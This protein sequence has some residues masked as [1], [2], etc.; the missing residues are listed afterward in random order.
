EVASLAD[1]NRAFLFI[2]PTT[3]KRS[4]VIDREDGSR[5]YVPVVDGAATAT[6]AGYDD[7]TNVVELPAGIEV[8][9]NDTVKIRYASSV[10]ADD[11]GDSD[12]QKANYFTAATDVNTGDHS[13]V[14]GLRQGQ[15]EIY[16]VDPDVSTQY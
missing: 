2:D 12:L 9:A 6:E 15:I 11:S 3:G 13:N 10:Y 14:G 4:V 1:S 5:T 16:L 7:S 8:G